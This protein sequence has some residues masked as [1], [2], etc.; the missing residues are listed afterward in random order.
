[1]TLRID[2]C[3]AEYFLR[4]DILPYQK[5]LDSDTRRLLLSCKVAY[6]EEIL[7]LSRFWIPHIII[8]SPSSLQ[9]KLD[10][11]LQ[12]YLQ[13]DRDEIKSDW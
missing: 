12:S 9:A 8:L 11:T 4:R 7:R 1:V 5:I 10:T 2:A 6:E 3:V 13:S